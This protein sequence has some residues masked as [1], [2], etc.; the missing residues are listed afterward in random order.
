M[1]SWLAVANLLGKR[2]NQTNQKISGGLSVRKSCCAPS[3]DY[4]PSLGFGIL[5]AVSVTDHPINRRPF[6]AYIVTCLLA[7]VPLVKLD[8]ALHFLPVAVKPRVPHPLI[9]GMAIRLAIERTAH[10]LTSWTTI[11]NCPSTLPVT[12]KCVNGFCFSSGHFLLLKVEPQVRNRRR[13]MIQRA[14]A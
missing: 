10:E 4:L 11:N 5:T 6:P 13:K 7:F 1:R 8:F 14:N 9:Y 12:G 3:L 2:A